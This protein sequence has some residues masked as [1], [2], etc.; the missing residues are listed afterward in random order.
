MRPD[1]PRGGASPRE[2]WSEQP[3]AFASVSSLNT[4]DSC[5]NTRPRTNAPD[6]PDAPDGASGC[7]HGWSAGDA[8]R[9]GAQPV[10]RG[11][12]SNPCPGGVEESARSIGSRT[13]RDNH[14]FTPAGARLQQGA[15]SHRSRAAET[16]LA[17]PVDQTSRPIGA[18]MPGISVLLAAHATHPFRV[19]PLD[20]MPVPPTYRLIRGVFGGSAAKT[21]LTWWN[22]CK[23]DRSGAA[24]LRCNAALHRCFATLHRCFA[25]LH[26]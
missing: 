19:F 13:T 17:R 11:D 26:R 22:N 16:S 25:A 1:E 23:I 20:E 4:F 21:P 12:P 6:A 2:R 9:A 24:F 15:S 3:Q 14:S 7:S 5:E 10:D 18:K 8:K